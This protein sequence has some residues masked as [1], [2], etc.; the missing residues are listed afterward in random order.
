MWI[1]LPKFGLVRPSHKLYM[2]LTVFKIYFQNGKNFFSLFKLVTYLHR[3]V[4]VSLIAKTVLQLG[5]IH[6]TF[7]LK[8]RVIKNGNSLCTLVAPL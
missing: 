1:T 7:K 2:S 8:N 6:R 5:T 4:K 3:C